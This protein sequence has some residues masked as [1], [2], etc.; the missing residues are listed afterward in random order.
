MF[1]TG[2]WLVLS[3]VSVKSLSLALTWSKAVYSHMPPS[4]D[5]HPIWNLEPSKW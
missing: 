3:K 4:T 5:V 2:L 1:L